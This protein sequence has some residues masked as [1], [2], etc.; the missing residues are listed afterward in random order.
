MIADGNHIGVRVNGKKTAD[1]RDH[2]DYGAFG[3]TVC[4]SNV[5]KESVASDQQ[6]VE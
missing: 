3:K 4:E 2:I 1:V 6:R 5:H